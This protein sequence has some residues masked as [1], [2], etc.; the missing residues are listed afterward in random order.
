LKQNI[1]V[2]CVGITGTGKTVLLNGILSDLDD[3]YSTASLVFS[4]QTNAAKVQDFIESKLVKRTK[5]KSKQKAVFLN[6]SGADR[7]EG[8]V[9]H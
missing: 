2:L 9:L 1:H 8:H 5:N 3:S 4:A 7:E 6:S